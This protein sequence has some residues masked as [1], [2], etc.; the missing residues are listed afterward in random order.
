MHQFHPNPTTQSRLPFPLTNFFPARHVC[1]LFIKTR[2]HHA[3]RGEWASP[4]PR[5]RQA[6]RPLHPR[7]RKRALHT[8]I[9]D[10][11]HQTKTPCR[12]QRRIKKKPRNNAPIPCHLALQLPIA[13]AGIRSQTDAKAK[14]GP[15]SP[16]FVCVCAWLP[17]RRAGHFSH[18]PIRG[19]NVLLLLLL[20]LVSPSLEPTT[21]ERASEPCPEMQWW[22][23]RAVAFARTA[24]F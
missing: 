7:G 14:I 16:K 22:P 10:L 17:S 23:P 24:A 3:F 20:L 13:H 6:S 8:H 1:F 15:I 12:R 9:F 11:L 19:G 5:T 4:F 18:A 21:T 2:V